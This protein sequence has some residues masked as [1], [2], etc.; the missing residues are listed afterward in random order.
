MKKILI[1]LLLVPSLSW[2]ADFEKGLTAAN[3]GDYA[4][5]IKEWTPLAEQGNAIAQYNLGVMYERGWGVVQN[6]KTAVKWYTLAAEQGYASAQYNIGVL[7]NNGD[8]V[9]QNYKTAV[10]WYTL[11]AEQGN[12]SGQ[13]N[14]GGMYGNGDGVLQ[15]YI[16]AHMWYNIAASSGASNAAEN[17]TKAEKNMTTADISKAQELARQCVNKNYKDC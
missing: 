5:A 13:H 9:V 14:L 17:R 2:G 16:Y 7:Y 11:A 1:L 4:T 6:Y 3:Q 12:A 8:G 10:K 15:N